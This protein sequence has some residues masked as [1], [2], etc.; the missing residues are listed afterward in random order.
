MQCLKASVTKRWSL[1]QLNMFSVSGK[2]SPRTNQ[3]DGRV[4]RQFQRRGLTPV[5][6]RSPRLM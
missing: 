1:E 3:A 6:A 4:G 5:K 2:K